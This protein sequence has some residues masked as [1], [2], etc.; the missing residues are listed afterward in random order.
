[1]VV[2]ALAV[3]GSVSAQEWPEIELDQRWSGFSRPVHLTHAGD[4]SGRVFVVEQRGRVRLIEDGGVANEPFLD[5][6][7]RVR[8]CG[9]QG[10]LS[11]AFP[12][13]FAAKRYFYVNYTDSGGDTV[14]S[15]FSVSGDPNRADPESEEILL[16]VEQPRSNHNGGQIAF[17]PD[18]YLY[19][20]M[21]DGGGA[22]DPDDAGQDPLVL[23]GKMLRI[24]VESGEVPYG[25]PDTNPFAFDDAHQPEIWAS[26]LR[27]PWR[28]AFDPTEGHL[29]IADVGQNAWEEVNFQPA[30]SPGGENYG[31]RIMEGSQCFNP[32][33]C[34]STG[35]VLPVA[36]YGHGSAGCSITGGH[37][38]RGTRWPRLDGVYLYGDYCSGR[39][40]GLRPSSGSWETQLLAA[41]G[42]TISSFG[43]DELG[44]L[45]VLDLTAGSAFAIT[46][47]AAESTERTVVPAVAHLFGS[48]GTP[49]RSELTI[50]NPAPGHVALEL[51]FRGS[52]MPLQAATTIEPQGVV[53]WPD[54]LVDLFGMDP[55]DQASGVVEI[56]STGPVTVGLRSYAAIDDGTLGQFL[57]G[58]NGSETVGP[59]EV[60]VVSQLA[61]TGARYTNL[62]VVNVHDGDA[63]VAVTLRDADGEVLGQPQVLELEPGEWKQLNDVL[64]DFGDHDAASA[65]IE[66][67][68]PGGRVWAY[69]SIIDRTSRD[70]T[71]IPMQVP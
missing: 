17:G 71:T 67:M 16:T 37:V 62:G 68:S 40:W 23:L 58:L 8:C 15:R 26:G 64:S 9:E 14:V 41:S 25:I 2:V 20:G 30:S 1:L 6:T 31:W 11:V 28:F 49:W 19:I 39:I 47:P 33:Q 42:L 60:G 65:R 36:E 59:G 4:G 69:A 53:S 29:Y 63:E 54:V 45:Y 32:P 55:G 13:G 18:G 3:G 12:P 35:L 10:L 51:S 46:D 52:G 5:I 24:D 50:A 61:R 38:Y 48:G 27:N 44:T 21:G 56:S 43:R 70:P 34:D 57:P 22:G 66:V 7:D